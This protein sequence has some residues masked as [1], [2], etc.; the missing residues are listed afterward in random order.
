MVD[1]WWDTTLDDIRILQFLASVLY[2]CL[3]AI[4]VLILGLFSEH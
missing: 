4:V 2:R 3:D 1:N